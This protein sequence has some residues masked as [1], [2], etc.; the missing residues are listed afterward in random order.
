MSRLETSPALR[1]SKILPAIWRALQ[2]TSKV[3]AIAVAGVLASADSAAVSLSK[4]PEVPLVSKLSRTLHPPE[5]D[6]HAPPEARHLATGDLFA[7][8][9]AGH[10]KIIQAIIQHSQATQSDP[11]FAG[12]HL[13]MFK[14]LSRQD[15]L[16]ALKQVLNHHLLGWYGGGP[17]NYLAA[18]EEI[19]WALE[20]TR[21][22][23]PQEKYLRDLWR[24]VVAC[25]EREREFQKTLPTI[26]PVAPVI[27]ITPVT[28]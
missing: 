8:E 6:P 4:K 11:K 27:P 3:A 26:P 24:E 12:K 22:T 20:N 14:E 19:E 5:V 15:N 13:Q 2:Q 10:A 28:P 23:S 7:E 18:K 1:E 16:P 21:M 9:Q 25:L 17:V